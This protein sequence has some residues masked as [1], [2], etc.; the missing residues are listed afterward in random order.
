MLYHLSYS[1]PDLLVTV[2]VGRI[3]VEPE[4]PYKQLRGLR[5]HGDDSPQVVEAK[6]GNVNTIDLH[7]SHLGLNH[8]EEGSQQG[9]LASPRP[10]HN[11]DLHRKK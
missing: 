4:C 8:S 9:G 6:L 5:N 3:Q 10:S 11:A 7:R 1:L 2:L